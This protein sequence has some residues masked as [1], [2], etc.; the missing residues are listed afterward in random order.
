MIKDHNKTAIWTA[1]REISYNE[2]LRKVSEFAAQCPSQ[3]IG[4]SENTKVVIFSENRPAWIYALYGIWMSGGTAVPVDCTVSATD[5]AYVLA[6]CKPEAI[7]VS[8]KLVETAQEAIELVEGKQK[9]IV[10]DRQSEEST[11]TAKP[12]NFSRRKEETA[13]I[14]YTSGTTGKP[15]GVM[16]SFENLEVNVNAVTSEE[17]HI[18]DNTSR[19]L[20]LLPLHHILPLA[21]T[22]LAPLTI[23]GSVVICPGMSAPELMSTLSKSHVSIIIGVPRLYS[24][25]TKGIMGKINASKVTRTLY[26]LCNKVGSR[27][28]S[29]LVFG[30]IRRKM[31]GRIHHFVS[32]GAALDPAVADI[33]K[34]LGL[35]VLEGYGMT[36]CA[37][38]ISFTRPGDIVPGASGQ[39]VPNVE[40]EIRDG[41]ICARGR[42]VMQ[43][44][45]NKPEE[46]A[47]VIDK[48]GWIHTGD[49]GRI[50]DHGRLIVT[51]RRKEIIVLSNGKNV[52]PVEIEQHLESYASIV[53]EAAVTEK[54]D[55]L[56]AIIVPQAAAIE[57]LS[58]EA[59]ERK[60]K[61]E[62]LEPYNTE[63]QAYKKIFNLRVYKGELPRTRLD[64]IQR[65]KL[66]DLLNETAVTEQKSSESEIVAESEEY[67]ILRQYIETEK[68]CKVRPTDHIELDLAFDSLDKVGLQVFINNSFGLSLT[69]EQIS[70][71]HSVGELAQAVAQS[72]TKMQ[73][74]KI[75][76]KKIL[77]EHTNLSLPQT[78]FTGRVAIALMQPF[79]KLYF[80][81]TGKGAERIPDG[82]VIIAPNHQS[83]IDGLFVMSFLKYRDLKNTYFY[84]KEQHVKQP[85]VKFMAATHNVIVM[86]MNNLKDSIQKM[87]EALKKNKNLIIFPEGTR[88]LDGKLSEFKK[89][90]AILSKELNIPIVPVS[91][92]GAFKAMPKGTKIPRP[93]KVQ[94]E[95]LDPVYPQQDSS[96]ESLTDKTYEKIKQNQEEVLEAAK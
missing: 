8:E 69:T 83:F 30:S 92:K 48:D 68:K 61:W 20:I 57:G 95:F 42:N 77:R 19:A 59:I 79:F 26:S 66:R 47:Q 84:A 31:G 12:A 43:G 11:P 53:R 5:L 40:V 28:L 76:W 23:G 21:G 80:K 18:Y 24:M 22:I 36:E 64:K 49:L 25:L 90:F 86:D 75:D 46:T 14:A 60:I 89:T 34:T 52:N 7:M 44:Y 27:T 56:V 72:K 38:M 73:V 45:Y 91:I 33:M 6:D 13:V 93:H 10:L 51:G 17:V 82:P 85:F 65:F 39:P 78:W 81:L 94:V 74:E 50:D 96:Y 3:T 9:I 37:P 4:S 16:L 32:G 29:R 35:D 15:K 41:E 87:G 71:Y 62:V 88:T 54:D 67:K 1:E 55:A 58:D 2:L 70:A 63:A